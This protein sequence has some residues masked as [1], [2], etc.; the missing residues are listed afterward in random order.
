MKHCVGQI[1]IIYFA[2]RAAGAAHPENY[3]TIADEVSTRQKR[4][5]EGSW[6]FCFQQPD[7]PRDCQEVNSY[8]FNDRG[9]NGPS[10]DTPDSPRSSGVYRIKP[11]GYPESF[12]VYCNNSVDGGGWTV[13]QRRLDGS[14]MFQR[15]WREYKLGFGFPHRDMWLGNEK[16]AYLT[17]QKNYELRIDFHSLDGT[18][19]FEKYNLFRISD[20]ST[21]YRL[22]ALGQFIGTIGHDYFRHHLDMDFST[23]DAD[24]DVSESNC[25]AKYG[26]GGWW[27]KNCYDSNLNGIF[28]NTGNPGICLY[29]RD[30]TINNCGL[31][32][33][34]MMIRP[35]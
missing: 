34:E 8:C 22:I 27:Y 26:G 11:D 20:E 33:V 32:Y 21:N 3:F 5:T 18:P 2:L 29:R 30:S 35:V 25:A 1:L 14:V 4:N 7:Y 10:R 16:L 28:G 15:T 24:N 31:K 9:F 13:F 23:S 6:Y 12:E 19:T 17:N